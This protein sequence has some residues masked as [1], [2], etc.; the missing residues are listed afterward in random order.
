MVKRAPL[1]TADFGL[2]SMAGQVNGALRR[3][4]CRGPSGERKL[5]C[6]LS[7]NDLAACHPE[8][9]RPG[10]RRRCSASRVPSLGDF[11]ALDPACAPWSSNFWNNAFADPPIAPVSAEASNIYPLALRAFAFYTY[12]DLPYPRPAL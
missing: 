9:H 3:F 2:Q 10:S 5:E 1:P 4:V 6:P 12:L 11:A 8:V 7:P